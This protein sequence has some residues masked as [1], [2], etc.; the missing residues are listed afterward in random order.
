M[1]SR[2]DGGG[3][4]SRDGGDMLVERSRPRAGDR[5]TKIFNLRSS[6]C[7]LFQFDCEAVEAAEVKDTAEVKLMIC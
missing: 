2:V 5:V 1:Q 3:R 4:K 6:E 7:T